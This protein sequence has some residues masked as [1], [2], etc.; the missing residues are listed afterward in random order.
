ML[1]VCVCVCVC[2]WVRVCNCHPDLLAVF[3][4]NIFSRMDQMWLTLE[5]G[6]PQCTGDVKGDLESSRAG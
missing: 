2:G 3:F 6:S 4:L 5:P 1:C